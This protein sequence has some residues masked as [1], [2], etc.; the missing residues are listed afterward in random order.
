MLWSLV[1][2]FLRIVGIRRKSPISMLL[3]TV[4]RFFEWEHEIVM[5]AAAEL[6]KRI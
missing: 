3:T 1:L 4:T 2:W 6:R 5:Q